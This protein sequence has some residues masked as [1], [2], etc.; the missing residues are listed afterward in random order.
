MKNLGLK[1]NDVIELSFDQYSFCSG[2]TDLAYFVKVTNL[3]N[4]KSLSGADKGMK[5]LY[6]LF[7]ID[8]LDKSRIQRVVELEPVV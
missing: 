2:T 6:S 7:K 5:L 8:N 3:S 1:I 4:N